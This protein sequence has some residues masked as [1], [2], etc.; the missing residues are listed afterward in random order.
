MQALLNFFVFFVV[1]QLNST[2]SYFTYE[3]TFNTE[4]ELLRRQELQRAGEETC[5][6]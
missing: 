2:E 3:T 5:S 4:A 1:G 6:N